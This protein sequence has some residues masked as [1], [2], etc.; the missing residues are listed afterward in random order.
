MPHIIVE[1]SEH[2]SLDIPN[3]LS[4]LH[5]DLAARDTIDMGAIKTRAH[6][7]KDCVV[8][9][10]ATAD[11]FIHIV[12]K[13]LPGRDDDLKAQ[14]SKGLAEVAQKHIKKHMVGK[15]PCALTVETI[16]LE[17]ETYIK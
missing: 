6:A 16:T 14:M 4:D 1:Y 10:E 13:L 11:S 5:N 3:L 12:L 15:L 17:A 9:C 8:G 7:A 2:L